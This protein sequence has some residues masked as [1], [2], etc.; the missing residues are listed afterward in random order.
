MK[1][2]LRST[3]NYK[4]YTSVKS[5]LIAVD[6]VNI[7]RSTITSLTFGLQRSDFS[8]LPIYAGLDCGVTVENTN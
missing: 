7:I 6:N 1:K 8:V 5:A 2:K 4:I 3:T